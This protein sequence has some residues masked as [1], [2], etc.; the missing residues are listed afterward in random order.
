MDERSQD[1]LADTITLRRRA[2]AD[3]HA[4]WL[5]VLFFGLAVVGSAPLYV[6]HIYYTQDDGPSALY[7]VSADSRL[8]SYWTVTLLTGALLTAWWYR[9]HG[10]R[11]GIEGKVGPALVAATAVTIAFIVISFLP[12]AG[13]YLWPILVRDYAALLVIAV[14]LLALAWQ[15]RS[16]GLWV[17]AVLF[18]AAAVIA[19]VYNVENVFFD[20]GWDPFKA[21]PDQVRFV[22]L[23]AL[24]APA[25]VLVAGGTAAGLRAWRSR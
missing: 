9:R 4:Y 13:F 19:N 7:S 17:I 12:P 10:R 21:H 6:Q 24:L 8:G 20:L 1:L 14:G 15:E 5:P 3:R 23:P 16:R 2:R 18:T 22:E 11:I 25:V